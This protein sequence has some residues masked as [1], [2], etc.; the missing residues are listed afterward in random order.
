MKLNI[1][2]RVHILT[3]DEHKYFKGV[4]ARE[5]RKPAPVLSLR[6]W[7][8]LFEEAEKRLEEARK[9]KAGPRVRP[10]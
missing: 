6:P 1:A 8:E 10:K 2:E 4:L 5:S 3:P 9:G 7:G